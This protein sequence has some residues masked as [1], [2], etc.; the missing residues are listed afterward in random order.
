[1]VLENAGIFIRISAISTQICIWSVFQQ[2]PM[3]MHKSALNVTGVQGF[4]VTHTTLATCTRSHSQ[5]KVY[6]NETG[7]SFQQHVKSP[8]GDNKLQRH[9]VH[10]STNTSFMLLRSSWNTFNTPVLF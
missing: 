4:K 2:T 3:K 6:S 1:M 7:S 8:T 10:T 9:C 5:Y